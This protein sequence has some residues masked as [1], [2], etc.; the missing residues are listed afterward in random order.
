MGEFELIRWKW[1][2]FIFAVV[3]YIVCEYTRQSKYQNSWYVNFSPSSQPC[4]AFLIRRLLAVGLKLLSQ[5][6]WLVLWCR[7]NIGKGQIKLLHLS[8][9]C[10]SSWFV[11]G[12][13]WQIYRLIYE[14]YFN[15]QFAARRMNNIDT[16]ALRKFCRLA[17]QGK[18]TFI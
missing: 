18:R 8:S 15:V 11:E 2:V 6:L 1:Y 14:H 13:H 12:Y 3:K 7:R 17:L 16:R 9:L 5:Y 4:E 10:L